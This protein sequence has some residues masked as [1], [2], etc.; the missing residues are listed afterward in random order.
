MY[1]EKNPRKFVVGNFKNI[2]K[3]AVHCWYIE[4]TFAQFSKQIFE[5]NLKKYIYFR[6]HLREN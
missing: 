5:I 2:C 1:S 6:R 3:I 4:N